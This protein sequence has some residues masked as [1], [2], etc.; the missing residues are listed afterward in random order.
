[1]QWRGL[2]YI[3]SA[4]LMLRSVEAGNP[5]CYQLTLK[6]GRSA[7][8]KYSME[9][10]KQKLE[11][12]KVYTSAYEAFRDAVRFKKNLETPLIFGVLKVS[13]GEEETFFYWNNKNK[14]HQDVI[15]RISS[16]KLG[17]RFDFAAHY[18]LE[19]VEWT[20]TQIFPHLIKFP[21]QPAYLDQVPGLK[22]PRHRELLQLATHMEETGFNFGKLKKMLIGW[23]TLTRGHQSLEITP[24]NP[25]AKPE[26]S[27][28]QP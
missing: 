9:K 17:A 11:R 5:R 10:L 19:D 13:I 20:R 24:S 27:A 4:L 15:N 16:K 7:E 14:G 1:M 21:R 26:S 23:S 3:F 22:L 12:E 2:F 25:F 6:L 18:I 28:S 8:P